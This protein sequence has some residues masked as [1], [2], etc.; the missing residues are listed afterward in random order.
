[1]F[2]KIMLSAKTNKFPPATAGTHVAILNTVVDL[3]LQES[4]YGSQPKRELYLAFEVTDEFNE[5]TDKEGPRREPKRVS[6]TVT[7]SLSQKAK[8]REY[9]EGM[10]GSRLSEAEVREFDIVGLVLGKPCLL[11]VIHNESNGN[12]YA[13]IASV[14]PLPRTMTPPT[15]HGELIAYS[16]DAHDAIV[17]DA[18]PKF[19][20]EKIAKRVI[21]DAPAPNPTPAG[22]DA[23][24]NDDIPF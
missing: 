22:K 21:E 9:V 3:G 1:M 7:A 23:D 18:L 6:T 15:L 12:T 10:L 14:A 8:L 16:P 19:L 11:N 24:F 2:P 5:W 20:Q 4:R 17:W 13:N